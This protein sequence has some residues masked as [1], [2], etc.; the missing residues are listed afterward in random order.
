M[1]SRRAF[2]QASSAA[3]AFGRFARAAKLGDIGVQLYTVRTVLPAKMEETL[4]AI[5]AAGYREIE[6]TWAGLDK[7]VEAMKSTRLKPVS[8]HL[9]S[10]MIGAGS[11]DELAQAV[12]QAKSGGFRYAVHPY[13]PPAERGGLDA[14]KTLAEKL[15]RA[16]EKFQAAGIALCYHNHA[17]E[18]EPL[19]GTT[20][21]QTLLENTDSKLLGIELDAFWVSVAGHDPA[22]LLRK[23][24]G[25]V[26]LLHVKDK[27]AGTPNLFAE[28]VPRT[29]FKEAGQGVL[30]WPK[31]LGAARTAGVKHYFVEQD[32]TPGDPVESLR[33]SYSYLAKLDY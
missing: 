28:G 31:V 12:E 18:F 4:G 1:I 10:K 27:A 3:A 6:A 7:L 8:V 21:F 5:E 20:P 2:L 14:M 13:V 24:S 23:L 29:A 32:Q 25:R 15:N 22:E 17:F 26:P 9:D 33:Q 19:Q 30:D 11:A 16:G